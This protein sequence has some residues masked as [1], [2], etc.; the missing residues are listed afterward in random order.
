MFPILIIYNAGSSVR[1][2][3]YS[4]LLKVKIEQRRYQPLPLLT[5]SH[6]FILMW[7]GGDILSTQN[8]NCYDELSCKTN[9]FNILTKKCMAVT[10]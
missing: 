8:G 1:D 7:G 9:V 10:K 3:D 4:L 5:A 2:D 6:G